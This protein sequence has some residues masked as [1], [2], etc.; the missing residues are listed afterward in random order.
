MPYQKLYSNEKIKLYFKNLLQNEKLTSRFEKNQD[1]PYDPKKMGHKNLLSAQD[2]H[3]V[4]THKEGKGIN[5]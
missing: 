5:P 2:I 3:T 4:F 1:T